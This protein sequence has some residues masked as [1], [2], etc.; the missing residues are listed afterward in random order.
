MSDSKNPLSK[1]CP[2]GL[3]LLRYE[4]KK[5]RIDLPSD[6]LI[7]LEKSLPPGPQWDEVGLVLRV[8]GVEGQRIAE[9]EGQHQCL[10]HLCFQNIC[11]PPAFVTRS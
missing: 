2:R 10:L 6:F 4:L 1:I 3:A 11:P 8:R 7:I 9:E 5:I